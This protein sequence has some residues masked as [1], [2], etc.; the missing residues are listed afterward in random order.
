MSRNGAA[1]PGMTAR[2]YRHAPR[3]EIR[4]KAFARELSR[5]LKLHGDGHG[6]TIIKAISTRDDRYSDTLF[7]KW[8]TLKTRPRNPESFKLLNRLEKRYRLPKDYFRSILLPNTPTES[9]VAS[10]TPNQR[11]IVRWHLPTDF[12]TRSPAQQEQILNWIRGNVLTGTTDFGIYQRGITGQRY[13]LRFPAIHDIPEQEHFIGRYRVNVGEDTWHKHPKYGPLNE[14]PRQ[15][16]NEL[17]ELIRFK[18]PTI[19][20]SGTMRTTGWTQT[21]AFKQVR[22]YGRMFGAFIASPTSS[23]EGF[24]APRSALTLA[25]LIF[26]TFWDWVLSWYEHRRGFFTAYERSILIDAI[27][28]I[29]PETGWINQNPSLANHLVPIRGMITEHAIQEAKENWSA[30]CDKAIVYFRGRLRE[31]R[32][33]IQVHRDTFQPILTVLKSDAP[34]REYRK[35]ADQVLRHF[36]NEQLRPLAAA[37]RA[38]AYLLL[39]FGMHLGLRQ[40]N[41]RQLLIGESDNS[42]KSDKVLRNIRRGELRWL[43]SDQAWEVYIPSIAFKNW[44]SAFFKNMPFRITL[45]DV[46]DLY[47]WIDIYLKRHRA[48]LLNG[49]PDP[50]TFFVRTM[51]SDRQ[52]G[53]FTDTTLNYLW[54]DTITR[55]GIYN[56]YTNRG[57]IEGLLPHG[58]HSVRDVIATH[59]IKQTSSYDLTA[60]ALHSTPKVIE[61]H[62]CRFLAEEKTALAAKLLNK[63]WEKRRPSRNKIA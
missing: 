23:I 12:N 14:A 33:V 32:R 3:R 41:L 63:V 6:A 57:A 27:S 55:F 54:R 21:T 46:C 20:P 42:P 18:R 45:S 61:K 13:G 35:I 34:L 16:I 62:Y 26:P 53:E 29:R 60:Y 37:E 9:A 17:T 51:V 22:C 4:Q 15:L 24:G 7:T 58:P 52:S 43:E 40:K 44:N 36:P 47:H 38:R 5:Q 50:G 31:L 11:Y 30:S 2:E 59:L 28:L 48:I 25:L 1:T 39:R 8:I 49:H 56:P 10:V 19:A